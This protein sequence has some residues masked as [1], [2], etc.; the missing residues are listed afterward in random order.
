MNKHHYK[1]AYIRSMMLVAQVLL[2]AVVMHWLIMQY[3]EEET[4]LMNDF[5][6]AW[7]DSQKQVIDSLLMKE[8]IHPALDSNSRFDFHFEF[9]T[10]SIKSG[11]TQ[12][13]SQNTGYRIP[14]ITM[15]AGSSRIIVRM[16]DS[17]QTSTTVQE[18]K[19][20]AVS[21]DLVLQGVKLF[22][23]EVTDSS[24]NQSQI[25]SSWTMEPD[26]ALMKKTFDGKVVAISPHARIKWISLSTA[27]SNPDAAEK[28]VVF[29]MESG[30]SKLIADI[31][32][33]RW[34]LLKGIL[35][36]SIFAFLLT[37]LTSIAFI[38]SFRSLKAQLLLN[39]QR[40]TFIRNMSH[41]LKTPVSTVKVALEALKKFNQ[42]QDTARMDEYLGMATAEANRLELL[43]NRVMSIS[44]NGD[45]LLVIKQ[46]TDL[47]KLI[48]DVVQVMGAKLEEHHALLSFHADEGEFLADL[49]PLHF[50]GVIMN[51]I[52]NSLKYS[53]QPAII[54][55]KLFKE[56]GAFVFS[57]SDQ[58]NGIPP[59]YREKIFEKFFRVPTGDVHNIKGHGLGLSYA[60]EVLNQHQGSIQYIPVNE[61]GSRFDVRLP[62]T[63]S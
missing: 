21:R 31:A 8:Y 32:G 10:D 33:T 45:A 16:T 49:D 12:P 40:N 5:Q 24:G 56:T 57:I 35:P 54:A 53:P 62:D 13:A 11:S 23:N 22:V 52:D 58:G 61:G 28:P 43:I 29:T 6:L 55:L 48:D 15:P 3:R 9:N 36:Q 34:I 42:A 51:L 25:A 2:T 60:R 19:R 41:E 18:R 7:M 37:L 50:Q 27:D 59:I 47:K 26:T 17:L 20:G 44:D 4:S 46:R 1:L 63:H 38:I 30:N 39:E 14:P